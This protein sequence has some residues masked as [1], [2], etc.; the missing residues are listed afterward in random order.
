MRKFGEES[1]KFGA[2]TRKF[3]EDSRKFGADKREPREVTRSSGHALDPREC[4]DAS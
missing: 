4:G 3:G 2:K 1:R